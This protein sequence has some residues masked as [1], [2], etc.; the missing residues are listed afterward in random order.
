MGAHDVIRSWLL[1]E[2]GNALGKENGTLMNAHSTLIFRR[3]AFPILETLICSRDLKEIRPLC[4]TGLS[5][6][7]EFK[8]FIHHG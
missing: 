4:A 5:P 8:G 7:A 2:E 1:G 6:A 3:E